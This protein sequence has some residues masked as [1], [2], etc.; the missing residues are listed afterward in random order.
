[1]TRQNV[2][3]DM[4]FNKVDPLQLFSHFDNLQSEA[5]RASLVY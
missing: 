5:S 4:Y 3:V 2:V 1:M